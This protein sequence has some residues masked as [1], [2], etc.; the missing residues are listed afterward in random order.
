MVS[1]A[2]LRSHGLVW[3]RDLS[4]ISGRYWAGQSGEDEIFSCRSTK[5]IASPA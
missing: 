2:V 1:A 4:T 5:W 3:S